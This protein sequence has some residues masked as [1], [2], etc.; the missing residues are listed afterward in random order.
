MTFFYFGYWGHIRLV[1]VL[2]T[3]FPLVLLVILYLTLSSFLTYVHWSVLCWRLRKGC[4]QI[5][6]VVSAPLTSLVTTPWVLIP[7]S[8][9]PFDSQ[10]H[11]C[12]RVIARFWPGPLSLPQKQLEWLPCSLSLFPIFYV[13]LFTVFSHLLCDA[14]SAAVLYILFSYLVVSG[15]YNFCCSMLIG[16]T[17]LLFFLPL[18]FFCLLVFYCHFK[19]FVEKGQPTLLVQ[20][21]FII[22]RIKLLGPFISQVCV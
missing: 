19:G 8:N 6:R 2:G 4:L 15:K 22:L 7:I 12:N 16:N 5:S 9:L 10:P 11:L 18:W 20:C 13:S 17:S 21:T 3:L 14:L 1:W